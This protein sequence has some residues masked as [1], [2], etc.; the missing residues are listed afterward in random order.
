MVSRLVEE[1]PVGVTREH[2]GEEHPQTESA[3]ESGERIAADLRR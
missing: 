3:R 2:L 1:E